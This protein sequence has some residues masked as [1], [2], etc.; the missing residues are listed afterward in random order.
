MLLTGLALPLLMPTVWGGIWLAGLV[1]LPCLAVRK[2]RCFLWLVPG[3]MLSSLAGINWAEYQLPAR[4]EGV[5]VN[6]SGQIVDFPTRSEVR[7]GVVRQHFVF[8]PDNDHQRGMRCAN[9]RRMTL[10]YWQEQ[11]RLR[12]GD[13]VTLQVRL[14]PIAS[15]WSFAVLPDQ[16]RMAA[17]GVDA[18]GVVQSLSDPPI[19]SQNLLIQWRNHLDI[20]IAALDAEPRVLGIMAALAIGRG[21]GIA[22]ADWQ[23]LRRF[24]LTHAFVISGLHIGLVAGLTLWLSRRTQWWLLPA[25]YRLGRRLPVVMALVSA[26]IYSALAGFSIPVQR[27]LV[28]VLCLAT[29]SLLGWRT[30]PWRGLLLT[31]VLLVGFSPHRLL[32]S[33]LWMSVVATGVLIA[34]GSRRTRGL[35]RIPDLLRVQVLL[36]LAMA[37]MTVFWFGEV[38]IWSV[39]SNLILVPVIGFWIVPLVLSGALLEVVVGVEYGNPLWLLAA[40]SIDLLLRLLDVVDQQGVGRGVLSITLGLVEAVLFGLAVVALFLR[41]RHGKAIAVIL[42]VGAMLVDIGSAP[43]PES[44]SLTI[45]DVGQ[46]LSVVWQERDRVLLYDTGDGRAGGFSQAQKSVLPYLGSLG[47]KTLDTLVISHGDSDHSGGM[48]AI[49]ERYPV[50]N[51]LGYQGRPCRVGA[52]WRWPGGSRFTLLNGDGQGSGGSNGSSC[53][54]LIEY[55]SRRILLTGDIDRERER[56]LV[57]YWR[58]RLDADVLVAAHHG[59]DTSSG[60]TFLKWVTPSWIAV[61]AGRANH[62]GHPHQAVLDR[63]GRFGTDIHQ[64]ARDGAIRY[65]FDASGEMTRT[66]RREGVLPYWLVLP[67]LGSERTHGYTAGN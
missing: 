50:T 6:L 62:F 15:Q 17:R 20:A 43:D 48:T 5:S 36:V 2:G 49:D 26:W 27:A 60:W 56:H 12:L 52:H 1:S 19:P 67:A 53:V 28:M 46:G 65:R 35:W 25:R 39:A 40:Q 55:G 66:L 13:R 54:L 14:R 59:S 11:P 33:S 10:S 4:C 21:S 64:T 22:P 29:P 44:A 42:G 16:A 37:P 24:G 31:V 47:A 41:R 45:L 3:L 61:S 8:Q 51:R 57:R 58:S 23:L 38:S 30:R 34:L 9:S 63:L 32:S 7:S 18:R